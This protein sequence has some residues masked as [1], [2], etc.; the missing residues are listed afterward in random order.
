MEAAFLF[1]DLL[2]FVERDGVAGAVVELGRPRAFM[3]GDLLG[4]FECA[5][6][7]PASRG[8][9][10]RSLVISW[11]IRSAGL[12]SVEGVGLL[13]TPAGALALLQAI[14]TFLQVL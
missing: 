11:E 3:R 14:Q 8:T 5:A 13:G 4:L 7:L 12:T 1:L 6:D 9:I 2:D 10:S